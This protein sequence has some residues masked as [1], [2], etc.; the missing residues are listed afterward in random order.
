[1]NE[2]A[3]TANILAIYNKIHAALAPGGKVVWV[4]T[5]PIAANQS[6]PSPDKPFGPGNGKCYGV[7][8]AC[9]AAYNAAVLKLL[10]SKS[11][12]VVADVYSAVK[13]VCGEHFQT[14]SLQHEHDVHPSGPG[15]QFLAIE[16]AAT[17]APLLP[18][19]KQRVT[20]FM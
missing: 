14:C 17:I 20:T 10:G 19:P 16:V 18:K 13:G 8:D 11:D 5:T 12:V 6:T 2:T 3:Y 15:K 7:Q 9:V 1:M 4:T